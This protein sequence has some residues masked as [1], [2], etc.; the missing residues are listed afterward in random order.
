SRISSE[1]SGDVPSYP[2]D[3][4]DSYSLDLDMDATNSGQMNLLE[5]ILDSLNTSGVEQG[6]LSAAKSLDFFRS[7][8]DLDY[9]PTKK[10]TAKAA[11]ESSSSG[12]EDASSWNTG[13][14]DSALHGKHL[15]PSPRR[16]LSK[17]SL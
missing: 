5:E 1:D 10:S 3:S 12:G 8:E 15:P 6:K 11:D 2:E 13:Q 7:T 17:S 14:D 9:T 4:D 16:Q